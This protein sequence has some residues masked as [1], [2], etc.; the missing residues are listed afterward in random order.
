MKTL[1]IR[2]NKGFDDRPVLAQIFGSDRDTGLLQLYAQCVDI[3][4]LSHAQPFSPAR[5]GR[6]SK[7]GF[8]GPFFHRRDNLRQPAELEDSHVR[9]A[10]ETVA[11]KKDPDSGF[12]QSAESR[13][14]KFF[15]FEILRRLDFRSRVNRADDAVE[16]A[17]HDPH[18]G[19][20]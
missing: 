11:L 12:A 7:A 4:K 1:C 5:I 13:Y 15:S 18:V 8:D 14:A 17:G 6:R 16:R 19:S 20:C 3:E 2:L 9:A 10:L